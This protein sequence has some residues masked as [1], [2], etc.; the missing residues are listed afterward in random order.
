M[1]DAPSHRALP[2]VVDENE[3]SRTQSIALVGKGVVIPSIGE[4]T[5]PFSETAF[6]G[7]GMCRTQVANTRPV[8]QIWLSTLF[9]LA[10]HLVLT[11]CLHRAQD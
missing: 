8:G 6:I 4:C 1:Q 9:Y 3:S 5:E 2:A 10:W 11:R 7:I